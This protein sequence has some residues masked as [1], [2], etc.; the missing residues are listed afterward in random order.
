MER[1]PRPVDQAKSEGGEAAGVLAWSQPL[2]FIV[3]G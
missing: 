1:G 3:I 2:S